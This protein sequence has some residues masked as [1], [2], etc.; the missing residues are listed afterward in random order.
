[1]ESAAECPTVEPTTME[2]ATMESTARVP[3]HLRV[4]RQRRQ[5]RTCHAQ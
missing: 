3:A 1:M 5:S 2:S 4:R